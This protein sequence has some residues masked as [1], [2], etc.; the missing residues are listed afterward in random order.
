MHL[1]LTDDEKT[2][3]IRELDRIIDDDRY[4]LS[5]RIQTLKAILAKLRP[6]PIREPLPPIK[7]MSRRPQSA[8]TIS[9]LPLRGQSCEDRG[10][11]LALQQSTRFCQIHAPYKDNPVSSPYQLW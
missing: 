10:Y 2:A 7:H 11:S 6:E 1:D 4:P 3:L 8:I 9:L 5:P